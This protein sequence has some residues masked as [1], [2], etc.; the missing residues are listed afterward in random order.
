VGDRFTGVTALSMTVP[1]AAA[2]AAVVGVP[3]AGGHLSLQVVATAAGLALLFPILQYALDMLA[4]RR[5]TPTAFGTLM[6]LEPAM[7][8]VLGLVV[9]CQHPSFIQLAAIALVVLAGAGAQRG[10]RTVFTNTAQDHVLVTAHTS[11][12]T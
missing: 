7:G 5:M 3:H 11:E 4:L 12:P 6:A 2:T 10:R 8:L 1:I 9:L